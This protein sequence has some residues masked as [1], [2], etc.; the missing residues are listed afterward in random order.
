MN[1]E[2]IKP[3]L[4]KRIT[5]NLDNKR[6]VIGGNKEYYKRKYHLQYTQDIV[7]NVLSAFMQT[8]GEVIEEGNTVKL[9]GYM[10][11]K[12]TYCKPRVARNV[13][14]NTEMK[15]PSCYKVRVKVGSKLINA[16]K[17]FSEKEKGI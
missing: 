4:V 1:T 5:D 17:R 15:L 9:N 16:C 12:P 8:I 13:Y 14:D 7:D 2:I 3:E 10:T 6:I 11:I